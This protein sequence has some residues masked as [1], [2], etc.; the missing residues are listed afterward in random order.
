MT[1]QPLIPVPSTTAPHSLEAETSVLGGVLLSDRAMA[2]LVIEEGLL[3][4][5]F[6]R[7]SHRLVWEAMSALF[8]QGDPID[9]L[10]VTEH[11]RSSGRLEDA[12][13]KGAID[14]LTGGVPGLGGIRR[15]A[16]IV[17][18]RWQWRE[19]LLSAYEQT[20][21]IL[22]HGSEDEYD[23]ALQRAMNITVGY[24]VADGFLG[25]DVLADHMLAWLE[26]TPD[27]GLPVPV[28]LAAVARKI[29]L[30]A[31]HVTVLA[32]WPSGGKTALALQLAAAIGQAGHRVVIWTNEDTAEELVAKHVMATTGIPASV[33]SDRRVTNEQ[34]PRVMAA[35]AKVPFEVQPCHDWAA[36]QVAMHIRQERPVVAVVDHFHNLS[37]IG[38]VSEV[39]E[40]IRVLAA[41]AGQTGCHLVLCAQLNRN[42]LNGVCKPPPVAADLRG[43]AMFLAAAHT[44]LLPHRDEQE[45]EN[46][47]V[48][49]GQAIQLETGSINVAKN[50]VT[51]RT[52]VAKVVFDP[53]RL[54][55]VEAAHADADADPGPPPVVQEEWGF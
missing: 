36:S 22:N 43:S 50:K 17:V 14:E 2:A 40:S 9:V 27:E 45:L 47:G 35:I 15:Y 26:E 16:Q 44:M 10:T 21:V 51:G 30:R 4:E 49:L 28:E 55:F 54:R 48:K 52:G 31:G 11:L 37:G 7:E 13:G 46:N 41:A 6:Y 29:R 8:E 32:A 12:G 42:R 33:I 5:H 24:R 39:D 34:F 1:I 23:A 3:P 20:A 18:E 38:Q 53:K 25:K 19:R